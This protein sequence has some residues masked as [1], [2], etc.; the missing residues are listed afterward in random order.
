[1]SQSI[2]VGRV[3]LRPPK[4]ATQ[5]S[6][7]HVRDQRTGTTTTMGKHLHKLASEKQK[8]IHRQS[9]VESSYTDGMDID[10]Q[11][12]VTSASNCA[13][14]C[15][16]SNGR[17]LDNRADTVVTRDEGDDDM[18]VNAHMPGDGAPGADGVNEGRA[19]VIKASSWGSRVRCYPPETKFKD[20]TFV[21]EPNS[22]QGAEFWILRQLINQNPGTD[23]A[24]RIGQGLRLKSFAF[25]LNLRASPQAIAAYQHPLVGCIFQ[26]IVGVINDACVLDTGSPGTV[27]LDKLDLNQPVFNMS[28]HP[29]A[30]YAG[31]KCEILLD[32]QISLHPDGHIGGAAPQQGPIAVPESHFERTVYLKNRLARWHHT[33]AEKVPHGNLFFVI[34]WEMVGVKGGG[35]YGQQILDN[36]PSFLGTLRTSFQEF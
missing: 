33:D 23:D 35:D 7:W 15:Q 11:V 8:W 36:Y 26:F 24:S 13:T 9:V 29:N 20:V 2:K 10:S 17:G 6:K 4:D 27:L 30:K 34:R 25:K 28:K 16:S 21:R 14:P 12:V 32:E 1:M 3:Q 5:P 19:P 31:H 18:A 22:A